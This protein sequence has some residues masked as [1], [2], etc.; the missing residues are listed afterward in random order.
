M[1]QMLAVATSEGLGAALAQ[2]EAALTRSAINFVDAGA[3]WTEISRKL[4]RVRPYCRQLRDALVEL[5]ILSESTASVD[6]ARANCRDLRAVLF[7]LNPSAAI[8]FYCDQPLCSLLRSPRTTCWLNHLEGMI[9]ARR[10]IETSTNSLTATPPPAPD[11]AISRPDAAPS[12]QHIVRPIARAT[13]SLL[14][15]TIDLFVL[16]VAY[17]LYFFIDVHLQI[18]S[19]PSIFP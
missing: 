3:G 15:Q 2:A 17:L 5:D 4:D 9:A 8:P 14:R 12:A 16:A 1:E 10:R 19:L 6:K 18:L 13:P 11:Q 7:E